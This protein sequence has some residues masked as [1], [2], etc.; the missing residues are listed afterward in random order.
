M[1]F[2]V[3]VAY[4]FGLLLVGFLYFSFLCCFCD[5]LVGPWLWVAGGWCNT[6]ISG[7]WLV[8]LVYCVFLIVVLFVLVGLGLCN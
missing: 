8:L 1:L 5:T 6:E 7:I 4:A 2:G 3:W